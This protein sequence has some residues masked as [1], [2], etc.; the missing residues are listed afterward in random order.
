M[1]FHH[2]G[3][4]GL[5]LLTSSEPPASAS[6]S[7]GITGYGYSSIPPGRGGATGNP[8]ASFCSFKDKENRSPRDMG[9]VRWLTSIILAL[10]EAMA[11][12][13]L[14][15]RSL[16]PACPIYHGQLSTEEDIGQVWWL[17]PVILTLCEA[18][19]SGSLELLG[20]LRQ[21]NLL[22]PGGRHCREL[23]SH[24]CTPAWATDGDH[25]GQ[26]GLELLTSDDP[27]ASASQ[28][29]RITGMS[30]CAL[31]DCAFLTSS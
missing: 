14:E 8:F 30:H 11:G 15:A 29:A 1:G 5:K 23:R 12:G 7:F 22:N 2:V 31:S 21:E 13:S 6:P 20:R 4:A 18:K 9:R 17:M 3:Q 19:A 25:V 27:P 28:G 10:W 26:V 24:H 16:R